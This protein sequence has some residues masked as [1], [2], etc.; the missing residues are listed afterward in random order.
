MVAGYRVVILAA[1]AGLV[2]TSV[3]LAS[4]DENTSSILIF[5]TIFSSAIIILYWKLFNS[6]AERSKEESS[7]PI[8]VMS[9]SESKSL[10]SIPTIKNEVPDPLEQ[11]IDI[12]LM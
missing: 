4:I 6:E 12:P 10:S 5:T 7:T 11:E 3:M 2:L 9:N 8:N 1:A